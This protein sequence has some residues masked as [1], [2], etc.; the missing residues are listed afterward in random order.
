MRFNPFRPN[1]IVPAHMFC[2]REQEM[3]IVRQCLYQTKNEN[4]QN[5]LFEGERGIGKSSLVHYIGLEAASAVNDANDFKFLVVS[6]ELKEFMTPGDLVHVIASEFRTQLGLY[7]DAVTV[8]QSAW[9]FLSNWKVLGVEYK[10]GQVNSLESD[11]IDD[12]ARTMARFTE[13]AVQKLS[14]SRQ[15]DGILVLLDE[16]DK[17]SEAA[18]LGEF[19]KLFTERLTKIGCNRVCF[20]LTGLPTVIS[21][22]RGSHESSLR[23]FEAMPVG[24]LSQ[25][26]CQQ[27][28]RVAT[29]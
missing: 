9:E 7:R 18:R 5:F 8:A 2:G 22:L 19:L 23:L 16:A 10:K 1:G 14:A 24:V 17:P 26:A 20:G 27:V 15:I 6:V 13:G 4:P 11:V 3:Q 28:I 29:P 12:L 21:K 25:P